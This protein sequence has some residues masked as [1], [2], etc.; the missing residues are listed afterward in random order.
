MHCGDR[1]RGAQMGK[2]KAKIR[3]AEIVQQFAVR[4]RETR[5]AHSLTQAELARRAHVSLSHLSKLEAGETA[6]GL[7]LLDRLADALGMTVC[8]L[9][10]PPTNDPSRIQDKE[11]VRQLFDRFLQNAN[12]EVTKIA[13]DVLRIIA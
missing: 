6:P 8:K 7:D 5:H 12:D 10:P 2:R 13:L 9:L 11:K 3:Q 1:L 4:L